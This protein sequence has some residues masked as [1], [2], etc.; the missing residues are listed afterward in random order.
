[1]PTQ[2]GNILIGSVSVDVHLPKLRLNLLQFAGGEF[3]ICRAKIFR[4]RIKKRRPMYRNAMYLMYRSKVRMITALALP[5]KVHALLTTLGEGML[6]FLL[7]LIGSVFTRLFG[8]PI[9]TKRYI[10]IC[11]LCTAALVLVAAAFVIRG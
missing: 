6:L 10:A 4:D 5:T 7:C 8:K 1:L 2:L 3:H 11:G 9:S